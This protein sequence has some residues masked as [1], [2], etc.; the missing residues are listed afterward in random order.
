MKRIK[1]NIIT[2]E[3]KIFNNRYNQKVIDYEL[4]EQ[5]AIQNDYTEIYLKQERT[6][7]E[8]FYQ[9]SLRQKI[10]EI[11][12]NFDWSKYFTKRQKISKNYFSQ[13]YHEIYLIIRKERLHFYYSDIDIF[14]AIADVLDLNYR[15]LFQMISSKY[16]IRILKELSQKYPLYFKKNQKELF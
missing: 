9:T 7:E 11:Y 2:N 4:Y 12:E 14:C 3:D 1:K 15:N 16:K 5:F 6:P 10:Y 13:I 8:H